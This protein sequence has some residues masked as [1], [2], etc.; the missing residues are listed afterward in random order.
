MREP[1]KP[2]RFFVS[3]ADR[4]YDEIRGGWNYTVKYESDGTIY[5]K[6]VEETN[7]RK[8]EGN[9][10]AGGANEEEPRVQ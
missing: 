5:P 7:L 9:V 6:L 4:E 3:I 2:F 10:G 1:N 8:D